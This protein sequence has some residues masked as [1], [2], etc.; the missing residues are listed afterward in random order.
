MSERVSDIGEFGL[1]RRINDLLKKEGIRSERVTIGIGDDTASFLPRPGYELLVTC[2]CMVEGRHYL[3]RTDQPPGFG[4]PGYGLKHQRHRG[5]GR[6]AP[7][8]SHLPWIEGR[9]L[10]PGYRRDVPGV[11]CGTE[12]LWGLNHRRQPYKIGEWDVYR[13]YPDRGSGTGKG[14][15]PF[16]GKAGRCHPGYRIPGPVGCRPAAPASCAR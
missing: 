1:I 9:D 4:A 7:L 12:P 5:H 16:R 11:S 2:D 15:A 14:G 3:P 6:E 13:H 8:C 10:G